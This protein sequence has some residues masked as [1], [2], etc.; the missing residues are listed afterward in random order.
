MMGIWVANMGFR[1]I[2]SL[3]REVVHKYVYWLGILAVACIILRVLWVIDVMVIVQRLVS[4]NEHSSTDSGDGSGTTTDPSTDDNSKG[5][6]D[7]SKRH[8][9]LT[10]DD[11]MTVGIQVYIT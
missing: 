1:S 11:I 7:P 8:T 3:H 6:N 10:A 9:K 2:Q 4:Q 5:T